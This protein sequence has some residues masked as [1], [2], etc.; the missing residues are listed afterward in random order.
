[1][2]AVFH[3][4]LSPKHNQTIYHF[5]DNLQIQNQIGDNCLLNNKDDLELIFV[6]ILNHADRQEVN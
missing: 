1:M 6:V 2:L 3:P 5:N 4:K